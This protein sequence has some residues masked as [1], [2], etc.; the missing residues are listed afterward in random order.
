[1]NRSCSVVGTSFIKSRHDSFSHPRCLSTQVITAFAV[2]GRHAEVL[3][4]GAILVPGQRTVSSILRITGLC[5]E[6][7]FVNYH[8]ILNRAAW[9]EQGFVMSRQSVETTILPPAL[10]E[11][12]AYA[13]CHAA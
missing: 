11:G 13:L 10:R 5:R 4:V 2:P 9:S 6:P 1:M 8:R 12:I 7:R 3:L